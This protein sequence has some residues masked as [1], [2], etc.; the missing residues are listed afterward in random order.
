M[1]CRQ[2]DFQPSTNYNTQPNKCNKK[3]NATLLLGWMSHPCLAGTLHLGLMGHP[4][5]AGTLYF[6]WM[7]HPSLTV[8]G[9]SLPPLLAW[10]S[11]HYSC[12]VHLSQRWVS[13]CCSAECSEQPPPPLPHSL[14]WARQWLLHHFG[15]LN[16]L[17][18]RLMFWCHT[19]FHVPSCDTVVLGDCAC[20]VVFWVLVWLFPMTYLVVLLDE[21]CFSYPIS[22]AELEVK[23]RNMYFHI[24]VLKSRIHSDVN[25]CIINQYVF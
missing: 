11:T 13:C 14:G 21:N 22:I 2:N 20:W 5:L 23:M 17:G 4:W 16:C 8:M 3:C 19:V 7:S 25:D 15:P 6:G 24:T 10:A 18:W 12:Q 9:L 1:I